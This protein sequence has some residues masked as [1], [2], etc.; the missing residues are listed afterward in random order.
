MSV[1]APPPVKPP[2]IRDVPNT[3]SGNALSKY[4]VAGKLI[5]FKHNDDNV[6]G[7]IKDSFIPE[8]GQS[9][10]YAT[11]T[12]LNGKEYKVKPTQIVV[13][14]PGKEYDAEEL[15]HMEQAVRTFHETC[16]TSAT[17]FSARAPVAAPV[18]G[19]SS[20]ARGCASRL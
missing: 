10:A 14:L 6:L 20:G 4:L 8:K 2:T 1:L 18:S 9:G 13:V 19:C 17:K 16:L 5:Q 3:S 7:L 12:D 11:V 15:Q